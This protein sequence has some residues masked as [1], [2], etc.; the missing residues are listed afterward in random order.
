MSNG[1]PDSSFPFSA[2]AGFM[3]GMGLYLVL[4]GLIYWQKRSWVSSW[5]YSRY[6][7]LT[8]THIE[9]LIYLIVFQFVLGGQ[10]LFNSLPILGYFQ[11]IPTLFSLTLYLGGLAVFHA[12]GEREEEED[13]TFI[14]KILFILPFALPF[15]FFTFILDLLYLPVQHFQLFMNHLETPLGAFIFFLMG[16]L[17]VGISLIFLPPLIIRMWRCQPIEDG[18]LKS[19]LE[20]LCQRAHFRYA[21]FRTWTV[22]NHTLTAAILGVLPR[23]RYIIFT[24]RLLDELPPEEI[25]AILAH[26]I[27]HS[28]H[29]HLW[30]YPLILFGLVVCTGVFI[31]IFI[32]PLTESVDLLVYLYPSS[33]WSLFYSLVLFIP[34]LLI[35]VVYLRYVFGLFS[36]LFER[37][38]DLHG[39][40]IN[41]PP[42]HMIEALNSIAIGT[43]FS[44]RVPNWHHYSIQERMDFLQRAA[45]DRSLIPRF[46]KRVKKYLTIY[47]CLLCLGGLVMVAPLIPNIPPFKQINE[48]IRTLSE[49]MTKPL[50]SP[51]KN[52][53]LGEPL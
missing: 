43:G 2:T 41:V 6:K 25:E 3:I 8:L 29:R 7:I 50:R 11:I 1:L 26:E 44:H 46:H 34:I 14:E 4:L 18:F 21:D 37:Q 36:R 33:L 17:F 32:G 38:A 22:M 13:Q 5:Q 47:T 24:Q 52:P 51:I 27:G 15:L 35:F 39:F 20:R 42:E 9:L 31:Q 49:K 30:L 19:R 45:Q 28:Y 53:I 16:L 40:N 10:R 48:G 12:T 23:L